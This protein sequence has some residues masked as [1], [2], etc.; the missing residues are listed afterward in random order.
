M[1][2]Q[3]DG[4]F[5]LF[6]TQPDHARLAADAIAHW[7]ADG[8]AHHPRRAVILLATCEHDNGWIEEDA[9]THVDGDGTPLDFVAVPA[10]VRQRIWPRAVNRM[11]RRDPY[12]AAL[13]AHHAIAVYSAS[14]NDEG[15]QAF[16]DGLSELRDRFLAASGLNRE[17]LDA[18]YRF[19]NAADRLSLAFCTRWA[20]PLESYGRQIIL[21]GQMVEITPDPFDGAR[22]PLT[23]TARRLRRQRY[24]TSGELREALKDAA[25]EILR[26]EAAGTA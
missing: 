18:D 6:I 13:I 14:R 24:R 12:A 10:A 23:V 17:T 25:V 2:I 3:A 16:F 26:G 19:V 20:R 7:T 1:I 22:I 8:F 4:D 5:F 11:A 9:E 21:K 15:W